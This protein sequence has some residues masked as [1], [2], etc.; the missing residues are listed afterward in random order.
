MDTPKPRRANELTDEEAAEL[1]ARVD[2][3]GHDNELHA[4]K[5][6]AYRKKTG[7]SVEVDPLSG[8]DPSGADYEKKIRR[9]SVLFIVATLAVV[10][11]AQVIVALNRRATTTN[12]AQE[13]NVGTVTAAL[14]NGVSWG[15]G[16]TQFPYEFTIQEADENTG[17]V[18]VTVVDSDS[19]DEADTFAQAQIQATAFG[20]N[21]L[22]NPH[23]NTVIYHTA[24]HQS[25]SGKM[26]HSHLN[27]LLL[28]TGKIKNVVTFTWTKNPAKGSNGFDWSCNISGVDDAMAE[29]IRE[30]TGLATGE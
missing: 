29:K 17:R 7:H 1:F 23:V 30:K 22:Q 4:A 8:E 19:S 2:H 21:A 6:R 13:V 15:T 12:L 25:E 28:P 10:I 9:T 27:G 16:Y 5:Q 24:V 20:I 14:R 18:E 3:T 11:A 26:Q